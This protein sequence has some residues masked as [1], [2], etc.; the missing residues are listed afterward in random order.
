[1]SGPLCPVYLHP[2]A[3]AGALA[4][5]LSRLGFTTRVLKKHEY[6]RHP[7]VVVD[8]GP[9]RMVRAVCYVYAGPDGDG[10]WWFWASWVPGD[11]LALEP[12]APL[13]EVSLAADAV[14]RAV[15]RPPAV[16]TRTG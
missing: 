11:A 5:A 7:C 3:Q 2:G 16:F 13:G 8:S 6:A 9:A 14:A 1:V 12:A 15:T 10:Q 4:A